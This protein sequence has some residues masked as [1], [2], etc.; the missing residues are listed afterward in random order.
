MGSNDFCGK[1][2]IITG[3]S[4][5]IGE[6]CARRFAEDGANL[7]LVARNSQRLDQVAQ[8]LQSQ[9]R[10]LT[11]SMDVADLDSCKALLAKAEQEFGA[12]HVVVNN[13]GLHIRGNVE[14]NDAEDLAR[15]IQVNLAAP[16]ALSAAA[17]PYLRRAGAGALVMLASLAGKT[18]IQ[19]AATYAASKAGLR[20][21]AYSLFDELRGS[22]IAVGVV[23]PGPVDTDFIMQEIDQVEGIVYA[24]PMSTPQQVADAVYRVAQ[25]EQLEIAMPRVSGLLATVGY[26]FPAF[27]RATRGAMNRKGERNKAKYRARKS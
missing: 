27:R 4:A 13:A 3:A 7:V 17:I 18:P 2:V 6:A 19:G 5:G 12:V 1:T 23:S 26:L 11:V 22:G 24:Q 15:M 20:A 21:F 9:T 8:S 10:V 14:D 25:G 16:I